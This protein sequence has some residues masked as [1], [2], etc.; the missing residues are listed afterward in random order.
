[1]DIFTVEQLNYH[2]TI[3]AQSQYMDG[4]LQRGIPC[5][6]MRYYYSFVLFTAFW[7]IDSVMFLVGAMV[8]DQS[9]I[10]REVAIVSTALYVLM[11]FPLI[12]D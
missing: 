10:E 2:Q 5:H 12:S 6:Y 3:V 8:T 1:M 4:P 11:C 9:V 7:L